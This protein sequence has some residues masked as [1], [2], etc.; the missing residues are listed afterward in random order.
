VRSPPIEV[1]PPKT[2]PADDLPADIEAEQ[3]RKED[4][5]RK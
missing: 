2:I 3:L 1:S 4:S 5:W